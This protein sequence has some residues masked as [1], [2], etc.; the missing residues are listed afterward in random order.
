MT[1]TTTSIKAVALGNG[2]TTVWPFTF[3]IPAQNE[4]V[5]TLVDAV[6]G[7][8]TVISPVNYTVTGLNNANGGT[9]TYPLS[10]PPLTAA[11]YIVISRSMPLK[12]ETN[13]LNQSAVYPQAIESA[14]DYLTMVTQQLQDQINR[15][16]VFSIA[17]TISVTL[18]T[19]T[20]RANLFLGFNSSGDPIAI[21]GLTPGTTVSAAMIPVVTAPTTAAALT[22]LGIPGSLLDSLIPAGTIWD[23]AGTTAPAGFVLAFGQPCTSIYPVLRAILV[24]AGS[25]YGTNGVDPLFPDCRSRVLAGKSDMG[26][27][28]N[29]L[30]TGGTVLGAVFGVQSRVLTTP[31]LP[32]YTP[33]GTIGGTTSEFN[34]STFSIAGSGVNL[35][36]PGAGTSLT[37]AGTA[38]FT[39]TPQGGTSTAFSIVQPSIVLN[40]IVKAH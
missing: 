30:L 4:L 8:P 6:T 13:L 9:V 39:G 33:V 35:I 1:I 31:N 11:S 28:D 22:A 10:G 19:A 3:L 25:P 34:V 37:L 14:L 5:L 20:A 38:T 16:I 7:N 32:P 17:D 23:Y 24:G 26:G 40:K 21:S 27:V 18:P 2:A 12:Q 15:A 29:G 36:R